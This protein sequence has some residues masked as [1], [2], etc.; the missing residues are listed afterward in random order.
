MG[1]GVVGGEEYG[2]CGQ[3]CDYVLMVFDYWCIVVDCCDDWVV[4]FCCSWVDGCCILFDGFGVCC[5]FFVCYVCQQLFVQV[6]VEGGEV[7]M[8]CFGCQCLFGCELWCV[9]IVVWY[10]IVVEEYQF[11]IFVE[12]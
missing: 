10:E 11:C 6:D 5:D 4:L 9:V 2:F 1:D 7:V 8:D 12:G 3:V